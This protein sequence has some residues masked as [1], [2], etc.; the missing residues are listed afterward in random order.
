ML[1]PRN[2]AR[3]GHVEMTQTEYLFDPS[4]HPSTKVLL[5]V[6]ISVKP[7][8]RDAFL[9]KLAAHAA[10]I[11]R[12][13]GCERLDVLL[14]TGS[15]DRVCVWEIWTNRAAWDAHMSNAASAAWRPVAAEYVLGEHINV[16]APAR[17]A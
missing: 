13:D 4:T 5:F 15:D 12:E 16:T 11:R 17:P 14:D 8:M 10:G 6:E 3:F 1:R 9:E 7:G 2:I